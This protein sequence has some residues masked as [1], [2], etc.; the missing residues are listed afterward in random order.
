MMSPSPSQGAPRLTVHWEGADRHTDKPMQAGSPLNPP[1]LTWG[2]WFLLP[3]HTSHEVVWT[4]NSLGADLPYCSPCLA[5]LWL[6]GGASIVGR[7]NGTLK[8]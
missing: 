8:W 6:I 2:K 1:L 7:I 4:A 5:Q 3:S